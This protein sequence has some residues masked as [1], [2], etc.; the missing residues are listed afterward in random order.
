MRIGLRRRWAPLLLFF[1]AAVVNPVH[2]SLKFSGIANGQ[3]AGIGTS[4]IVLTIQNNPTE[5]G[6]VSWSGTA[7]VIGFAACPLGLSPAIIGGN[8]K[9]GVSQTQ[10]RLVS[11]TGV[12]S[13]QSLVV[14]MSISEPA[15]NLFTIE[16]L[17]LTIYS[18]TGV[19]L[20][21]TGNLVG[22]GIPPGGGVTENSS[23]LTIGNLGFGFLLDSAQAAAISPWICTNALVSGCAGIANPAN[24]L[25]RIGLA[26]LLTNV[27]SGNETFSVADTSNVGITAI[28]TLDID[29]NASYDALTDGL[30]VIRYLFGLSG[31][32]LINGALG[33][34]ATRTTATQIGDYLTAI[35][36]ALDIDGNGQADALTDGLLILRYLFGLRGASLIAGAV[37]PSA[38]RT[39]AS[40]IET[41]MLTLMP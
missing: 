17:S 3:G 31:A 40:A 4:N 25:N 13:G 21:N 12:Q 38:S 41:Q 19:Q 27:G 24:A 23:L 29:G 26:A 33:P 7:D 1:G 18:P 14:V 32:S 22:A 35:R 2:A 34:L 6:C 36:P 11:A 16:N 5:Q 37:G 15:G 10:T 8:E 30:L 39:T 20:Y 28:D 9:T